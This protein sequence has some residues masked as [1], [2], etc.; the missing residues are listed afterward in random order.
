MPRASTSVS[1]P[2]RFFLSRAIQSSNAAPLQPDLDQPRRQTDRAEMGADAVGVGAGTMAKL[3]GQGE[4]ERDPER[5]RF[6]VEQLAQPGFAFDRMA[7]AMA[8]V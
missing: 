3:G 1:P 6:A 5:D 7:E 2:S 8:E 4:S